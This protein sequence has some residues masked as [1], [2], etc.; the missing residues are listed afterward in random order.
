MKPHII[1]E[2]VCGASHRRVGKE[3][4][5]SWGYKTIEHC[6]SVALAVAD[7]HGSEA[8]PHS[9]IGSGIAV[10]TFCDIIEKFCRNDAGKT[11]SL[12][13]FLNR[14]GEIVVAKSIEAEWKRRVLCRHS[15]DAGA[16]RQDEGH[17]S[18]CVKYGSTLAGLLVTPKFFFALQIGDGNIAFMDD[19][20]LKPVIL[21]DR[22]LGNETYSLSGVH[23]WKNVICVT[24]R[25]DA[26]VPHVFMLST[27]GFINSFASSEEYEK[28]CL[29]YY[30]MI[31]K[32]GVS[33]VAKYL[34]NWLRETSE[35]GCGDDIS[36]LFCSASCGEDERPDR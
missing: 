14:E 4:Q 12:H 27:D 32:H 6:D 16:G 1:G 33:E 19:S 17:S 31:R 30:E 24:G 3:C 5:D 7:G 9:K 2:S 26:G 21:Q 25:R 35:M 34:G 22:I 23:S 11:D 10:S 15:A 13:T 36:V 8:C 29:G 18:I 20:G 28:S